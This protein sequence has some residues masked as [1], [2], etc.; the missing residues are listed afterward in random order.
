MFL[1]LSLLLPLGELPVLSNTDL[2]SIGKRVWQN[3]AAGQVSGLTAW[4]SGEAFASLGIGH[5][6]W[7]PTGPKGPFEESFPSLLQFLV[8]KKVRLPEWLKPDM[9]C[10]W[11]DRDAFLKDA[12]SQRMRE[13]RALLTSTIPLQSQFLAERLE[14]G[15]PSILATLPAQE[16]AAVKNAFERLAATP[17]GR[18]ALIDYVNFKGEGT[19]S[20]ERYQGKGWG[21]LQVLQA[22]PPNGSVRDFSDAAADVLKRR[23]QNAPAERNEQ[24]WLPGWTRRVQD[25]SKK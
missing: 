18:F 25:Y 4:N 17:E 24:R 11:T 20:T 13:L 23:V 22:M 19:K 7:Y 5:F 8:Q 21:L 3:E 6:I 10:P 16:R 15:L 12:Q 2:E 1:F 14:K 9:P